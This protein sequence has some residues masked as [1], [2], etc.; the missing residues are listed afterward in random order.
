MAYVN[1]RLLDAALTILT[2]EVNRLDI[3]SSEATTYTEATSTYTLGNKTSPTVG[4]PA[5]ATPDG[6]K[7]TVSAITDGTVTTN[8]TAAYWALSDTGNSRLLAT[9][10]LSSSQAVTTSNPFTLT[11][12]SVR[13]PDAV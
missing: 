6:R 9:G 5:D 2:S 12:F 11:A 4:S 8:G 3:T 1:D 10:P 7:V 13:I